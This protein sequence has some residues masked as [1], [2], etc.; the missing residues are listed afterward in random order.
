[1]DQLDQIRSKIDIVEL[2][3]SHL[4]LKKAGRNFKAL[5]PFHSEKTPS[6]IVS[7]ERQLWKCFGCNLGGDVFKFLMEYEKM[8]FVE[9]LRFLADKAGIKLKRFRPSAAQQERE[10]LLAVNHLASEF[11]HFI[12]LKHSVGKKGLD[13]LLKRGIRRSSIQLFKLGYAPDSWDSLLSYLTRKKGYQSN[14]LERAGLA[15]KGTKNYYDRFRGR[16]IFP[17]TDHRSNI[18]G[19]AGRTLKPDLKGAK[20]INIPETTLYHKGDLFYGLAQTKEAIKKKNK[21][22][23]VEGETD[24]ISSY[25]AGVKNAIAIKGSALTEPQVNLIKRFASTIILALDADMAGDEAVRRGIEI[26]DFVGLNIR[27]A[28]SKYGKDPDECARHSPAL[29]RESVAESIPVFDFYLK[30]ATSRFNKKTAE[31]KKKISEELTPILAKI[32][33]EV[34]KAHYVKKLAD[35]LEVSEEAV[36]KEMERIGRLGKIVTSKTAKVISKRKPVK[37]KTRRERLEEFFLSLLLQKGEETA[38]LINQIEIKYFVNPAI[39]KIITHLKKFLNKHKF[40]INKFA[41]VLPEE[42]VETLDRLYLQELENI[43]KDKNKFLREFNKTKK[44][45]ERLYL[46]DRLSQLA[47]KIREKEKRGVKKGLQTTREKFS[48]LSKK[49]KDLS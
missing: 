39:K 17:L 2:I 12:L 5:C 13:Y 8:T 45:V 25:Q 24:V 26:A 18:L 33:N 41:K 30:S 38:D 35:I 37:L 19:F 42:L 48:H 36:N 31:G 1:M 28:Q 23:I 32:T 34:V 49:L 11:Y 10:K 22:V 44:E 20:Y 14:D 43:L 46:K 6:F 29:W 16:I 15:I 27:V 4:P 21:A 40:E 47:E 9:A 3:N 7:P